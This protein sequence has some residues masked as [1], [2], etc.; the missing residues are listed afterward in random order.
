M[1]IL[2]TTATM[3][4]PTSLV[5]DVW[6]YFRFKPHDEKGKELDK[7]KA[8]CKLCNMEIK[9]C[10]NTTNLKNRLMRHHPESQPQTSSNQEQTQLKKL[11]VCKKHA[12]L[13]KI[14]K[15]FAV[16][17][18]KD[19]RPDS[20]VENNGFQSLLSLL[21]PHYNIADMQTFKRGGHTKALC[22]RK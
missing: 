21:E 8:V 9:Y 22:R 20:F 13:Q 7:T 10:C 3:K 11:F 16:F 12:S 18:C 14:T 6:C 2:D 4:A 1:A 19:I 17:I 5:A 15:A